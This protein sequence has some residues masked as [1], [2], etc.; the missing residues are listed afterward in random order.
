MGHAVLI[1]GIKIYSD[2]A[3]YTIYDCNQDHGMFYQYVS[4]Q[5]MSDPDYFYDENINANGTT[6]TYWKYSVY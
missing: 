6:F 2:H 3:V 4:S 1:S 5:A